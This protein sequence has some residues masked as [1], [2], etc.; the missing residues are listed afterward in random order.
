MSKFLFN[1]ILQ[2]FSSTS[3]P[4][5][6]NC[7]DNLSSF[8]NKPAY[9]EPNDTIIAGN[10]GD[11]K[12]WEKSILQNGLKVRSGASYERELRRLQQMYPGFIP[13]A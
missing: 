12:G 2:T 8:E 3:S 13:Q 4:A 1:G 9:S 7:L 10:Y 6:I 11:L 5:L